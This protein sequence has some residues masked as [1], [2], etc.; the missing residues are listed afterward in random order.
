MGML[1]YELTVIED[2][3]VALSG[4]IPERMST[5]SPLVLLTILTILVI[6]ALVF[7]AAHA[8]KLHFYQTRLDELALRL[9]C[10]PTDYNRKSVKSIKAQISIL[11]DNLAEGDLGGF[12][13]VV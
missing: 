11:E 2:E 3:S 4:S 5:T 7:G 1:I 8:M 12:V 10:E 9:H 13:P 6:A